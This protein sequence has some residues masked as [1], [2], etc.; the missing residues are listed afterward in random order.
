MQSGDPDTV[1]FLN[2]GPVLKMNSNQSYATSGEGCAYFKN[3]CIDNG[4]PFQEYVNRSTVKGGRTIGP[5]L[6][7]KCGIIA[8]DI[9]NPIL[10]MHSIRELGGSDDIYHMRRL[11]SAFL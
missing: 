5:M 3:L 7:A 2:R 9:G 11:F 1:V 8:V 4:I 10:A 6:S